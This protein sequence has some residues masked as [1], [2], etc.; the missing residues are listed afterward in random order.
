MAP[1]KYFWRYD[2]QG[3][4]SIDDQEKL[5]PPERKNTIKTSSMQDKYLIDFINSVFDP[6]T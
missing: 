3:Y 6:R 4:I 5:V 1:Q 2:V